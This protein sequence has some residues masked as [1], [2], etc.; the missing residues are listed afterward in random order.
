MG[1]RPPADPLGSA[2]ISPETGL[3]RIIVC[4]GGRHGVALMRPSMAVHPAPAA[5]HHAG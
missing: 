2:L 1:R 4:R 3:M 5:I